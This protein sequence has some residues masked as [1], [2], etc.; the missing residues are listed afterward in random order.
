[1]SRLRPE[2]I[3]IVLSCPS[4]WAQITM[5]TDGSTI[6]NDPCEAQWR[7]RVRA[8]AA[9]PS[10]CSGSAA[11]MVVVVVTVCSSLA[12]FESVDQQAQVD[13]CCGSDLEVSVVA[14]TSIGRVLQAKRQNR[15][16]LLNAATSR[17]WWLTTMFVGRCEL[18]AG[19][20]AAIFRDESCRTTLVRIQSPGKSRRE[21]D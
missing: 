2:H 6:L 5:G 18:V 10:C 16:H 20:P 7:A 17:S 9:Y 4:S 1:M 13:Q 14:K 3:H 11:R 21:H 15:A 19:A 8:F 12:E